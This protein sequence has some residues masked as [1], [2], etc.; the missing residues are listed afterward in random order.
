MESVERSQSEPLHAYFT[1]NETPSS[2]LHYFHP[3]N[4]SEVKEPS[5]FIEKINELIR[6]ILKILFAPIFLFERLS[7]FALIH[8]VCPYQLSP[9]DKDFYSDHQE[10][11]EELSQNEVEFYPFVLT[12][13]GPEGPQLDAVTIIPNHQKAVPTEQQKWLILALPN[14]VSHQDK[15]IHTFLINFARYT[16][17]CIGITNYRG[18]RKEPR[19]R[20][21]KFNDLVD[22]VDELT[23]Y[24]C[25]YGVRPKNMVMQG[26]S[27]GGAVATSVAA[28]HQKAGRE[29]SIA[30]EN[31]FD[32]IGSAVRGYAT[33]SSM[34]TFAKKN[35]ENY[36]IPE[37][38]GHQSIKDRAYYALKEIL[39]CLPHLVFRVIIF[40]TLFF[41]HLFQGEFLQA[42]YAIGEI[43][44][45]VLL[46]PLILISS[47]FVL[48]ASPCADFS[49]IL[50]YL[51]LKLCENFEDSLVFII[52]RSHL[53]SELAK[54]YIG[55]SN[56]ETNIAD[57]W[58]KIKGARLVSTVKQDNVIWWD[59]SLG[60]AIEDRSDEIGNDEEF[61]VHESEDSTHKTPLLQE[62]ADR[63]FSF[64][65]RALEIK[66]PPHAKQLSPEVV[67]KFITG[68]L[69]EAFLGD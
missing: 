35:I 8:M 39:F 61:Y 21:Q 67:E 41:D 55:W 3:R 49:F 18:A 42:F 11:I 28:R 1:W 64:L 10:R 23:K 22:D 43:C 62:N 19:F 46:D 56:W 59:A 69:E 13:E 33:G 6:A 24:L 54:R 32:H 38:E 5:P 29:M 66:F 17:L 26:L 51:N 30:A 16:G 48:F 9:C 27:L 12:P 65:E 2:S 50:R 63:Y 68:T 53:Y 44:K 58:A 34:V 4:V 31:T 14:F 20:P 15:R 57:E 52:A 36:L 37:A 7:F 47:I 40:A 60:K 25:N 45:T